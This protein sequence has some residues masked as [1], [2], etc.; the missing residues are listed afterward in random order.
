MKTK[1]ILSC[2][3]SMI[4]I[5]AFA[6]TSDKV[7][8][9][10]MKINKIESMPLKPDWVDFQLPDHDTFFFKRIAIQSEEVSSK[11]EADMLA[12]QRAFQ[13]GADY[14]GYHINVASLNA[15][16]KGNDDELYIDG[17]AERKISARLV[18]EYQ[19][20]DKTGSSKIVTY[21][22]LY[23]ISKSGRIIAK[24]DSDFD[25]SNRQKSKERRDAITSDMRR[26]IED[27]KIKEQKNLAQEKGKIN[28]TA[29]AASF[30]VPGA[31]Q[32][33]KGRAGVGTGILL[34][35]LALVGGGVTCYFLG[36]KQLDVMRGINVEYNDF[37]S[38]QKMYNTM[39][40]TSYTCYG[41]AAALYVF[42]LVNAYMIAPDK[43]KF[44]NWYCNAT[45]IPVN[46][47]STPTYAMGATVQIKF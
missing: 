16:L 34:G 9:L 40:I 45:V 28:G 33:Y 8:E 44:P 25:C 30:F 15:S 27:I 39:R 19:E 47:F 37:H 24:F 12:Q 21:W 38:A 42:N 17:Q 43:Y 35:E 5:S 10:E 20:K 32:M 18:C 29:L 1:I 23:E 36:K 4:T 41:A 22:Y 2:V 7:A 11:M 26:Q 46:E 6:Q 13:S 3:L 31:G 14:L